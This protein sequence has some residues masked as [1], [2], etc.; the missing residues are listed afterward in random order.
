MP[1]AI[2]R[3]RRVR[4]PSTTNMTDRHFV[5]RERARKDME[6]LG[7][8]MTDGHFD[9][10]NGFHGRVYLNAHQLFRHP[11]TDLAPGPGSARRHPERAP[12]EDRGRRRAGDRRRAARPH[13]RRA[14]RRPA[15]P[16][17]PAVRVRA[18]QLRR[19]RLRAAAV[20]R[21]VDAR[22][23][24]AA[25]RRRPQHRQDVRALRGAGPRGRRRGAG[26]GADLRSPRGRSSTSACRT[27]R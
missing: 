14:A 8:L 25:R 24:R 2:A 1:A 16:E 12:A 11:S 9:Y 4:N 17:P 21:R 22:S 18:V 13:H 20:L 15:Q 5:T 6:S 3:S 23:A 27:S 7:V 26:D 19:R 10:G